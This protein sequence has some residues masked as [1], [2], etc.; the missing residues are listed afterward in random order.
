MNHFQ[1]QLD[2]I[3]INPFVP[4]PDEVLQAIFQQAGRDKSPIPVQ[5]T[6]NGKPFRQTLVRYAGAWRL[7][8]NLAM[9]KNSPKR[10]GETVEVAV[11]FDPE[12][13][14]VEPHPKF[15]EAL[16]ANPE[17]KASFEKLPPSRRLEIVRYLS[18]LK[19]EASLERNVARAIGFLTGKKGFVGREKL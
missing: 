15:M 19:T 18:F 12:E 7:Y 16:E 5:G 9:L 2:I 17:A 4:L 10:I 11:G 13:R 1:A 14:S 8:V 3:G 6:L